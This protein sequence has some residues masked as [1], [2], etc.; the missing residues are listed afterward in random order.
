MKNKSKGF[1]LPAV[2]AIMLVC[3]VLL[4]ALVMWM[5]QDMKM[6]VKTQKNS[7]AFNL[8]EAGV[9]RGMWKLKSS[10]STFAQASAG[11]SVSR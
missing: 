3:M 9:D 2:L 6:A 5:Q 4:P 10:T 8:A 1:A 7:L 11:T